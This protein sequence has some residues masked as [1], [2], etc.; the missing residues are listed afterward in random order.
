MTSW[1][2]F[3]FLAGLLLPLL[4]CAQPAGETGITGT[5]T[6][7]PISGGPT[8]MG[9]PDSK[10]LA[11][12]EFAVK[13]GEETVATFT[14]DAAG[15]FSVSLGAGHY[16]IV[17]KERSMIGSYGPFEIEVVAG[18]MKTVTWNCDSGIR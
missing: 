2:K 16:S 7:S 9:V 1:L 10:P 17:K 15:H 5:I 18:K 13:K 11:Q 4:A 3:Y 8:R 14:T 12:T 6:I